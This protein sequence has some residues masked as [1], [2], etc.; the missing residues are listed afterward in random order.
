MLVQ[1]FLYATEK[2][3]PIRLTQHPK[4]DAGWAFW[5]KDGHRSGGSQVLKKNRQMRQQ[6]EMDVESRDMWQRLPNDSN[7]HF[8]FLS[9]IGAKH[10]SL[11][12]RC[13]CVA[14]SGRRDVMEV[15]WALSI[16]Q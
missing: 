7:I 16:S 12:G 10:M 3:N 6:V 2:H 5:S 14:K 15:L 1:I 4:G 13:D 11:P 8:C 9:Q